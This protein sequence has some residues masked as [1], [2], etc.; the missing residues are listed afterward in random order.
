MI[1]P[2]VF[3]KAII[4]LRIGSKDERSLVNSKVFDSGCLTNISI[5]IIIPIFSH[6]LPNPAKSGKN[7]SMILPD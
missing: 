4:V 1:P 5:S 7:F 3:A 6:I 2:A